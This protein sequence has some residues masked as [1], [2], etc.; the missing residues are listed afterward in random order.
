[1][2]QLLASK[3]NRDVGRIKK[4]SNTGCQSTRRT[5]CLPF[6]KGFVEK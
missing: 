4:D 6:M 3:Q 2:V 1:M 5:R